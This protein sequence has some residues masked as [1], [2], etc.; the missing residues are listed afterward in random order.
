MEAN[1]HPLPLHA[2]LDEAPPPDLFKFA[3]PMIYL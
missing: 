1:L 2:P 3:P